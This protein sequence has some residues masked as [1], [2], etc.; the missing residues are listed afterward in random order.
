MK[1]WTISRRIT[2]GF[3]VVLI[4]VAIQAA[5]SFAKLREVK[6]EAGDVAA[7]SLP[8]AIIANKIKSY[9]DENQLSML[10]VLL[11]KTS[12]ER[13]INEDAISSGKASNDEAFAAFE[14]IASDSRERAL[15]EEMLK[16]RARYGEMRTQAIA[17]A[18]AGKVDE[19]VAF[20]ASAVRPAFNDYQK[21]LSDVADYETKGIADSVASLDDDATRSTIITVAS[22]ISVLV[23]G[24]II[25]YVLVSGL[26]RIL[27]RITVTVTEASNQVSA[28]S[29]QVSSASQSLAEG[30]SRQAAS[31]EETSAS[32]EEIGSM[33][34][35]NAE[36]AENLR[37]ISAET[38]SATETG[39]QEIGKMV[40]AMTAIKVSSD[41]I[42]KIIKTI[43][44]IAFQTNIL[45]L[46]AA[47][48]AARAGEAGAG[49]AVVA[50]EVRALAQRAAQ[51]AKETAEKID[52][53]IAKSAHGMEI[54]AKVANVLKLITE[55][56]RSVNERVVEIANGSKEQSQ[57]LGQI[58]TAVSDM[59]KVT[60]SNASGAEETA[61]AAEEMNSQAVSL[62]ESVGE[63]QRLVGGHARITDIREASSATR[64]PSV[65]AV[66]GS[67]PMCK[68]S[69][70]TACLAE[71]ARNGV[72]LTLARSNGHDEF[73]RNS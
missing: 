9:A 35:R 59:D 4:L 21:V 57:G 69:P 25:A 32:L 18:D 66:R 73:F 50:D 41:N 37:T 70:A 61:A 63:L 26:N 13:K 20:N 47:V 44:E 11:A 24:C 8:G 5:V 19:A 49:F 48:E 28:A 52:D 58:S 51:A 1:N 16:A 30:S 46:N 31:L 62:I 34:K 42:A 36:G 22:A 38:S 55:R 29:S 53:S 72:S 67:S 54:S 56:S 10:R 12:D 6:S 65:S 43:D 40:D 14:K 23:L 3:A 17:L 45:A 15:Y 71:P 27:G 33:T 2:V 68:A 7:D 64:K 39:S 60:Q